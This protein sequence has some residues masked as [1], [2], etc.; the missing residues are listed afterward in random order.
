MK[1]YLTSRTLH[2]HHLER[3]GFDDLYTRA[4]ASWTDSSSYGMNTMEGT[5]ENQVIILRQ[6]AV[7]A[8]CKSQR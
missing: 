5:S 8:F 6:I 2:A 1:G 7:Q 4:L 3:L